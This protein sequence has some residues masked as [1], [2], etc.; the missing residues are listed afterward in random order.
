MYRLL[1]YLLCSLLLLQTL[2]Q[3]LLVVNYELNQARIMARYCVN[4]ARPE[5]KC[6]GKCHLA[7]QLRQAED[8][9]SK[10][11]AGSVRLKFEL[12]PAP[13]RLVLAAPRR[14][15]AAPVR[16]AAPAALPYADAPARG[17]FRPPLV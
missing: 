1:A 10:V 12:V 13:A 5:L 8:D 17:V 16:Y 2:E 6:N 9:S 11:P 14:W 3:E 15:P 4:R 7:K